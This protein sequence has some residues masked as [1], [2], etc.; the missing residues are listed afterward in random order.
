MSV[1]QTFYEALNGFIKHCRDPHIQASSCVE[2]I[3]NC[4]SYR[5]IVSFEYNAL[6]LIRNVYDKESPD[7]LALSIVKAHGLVAIVKKIVGNDFQ[8]PIEIKGNISEIEAYT[9]R[10]LDENMSNYLGAGKS[11]PEVK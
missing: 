9:K 7:D 2:D 8:I 5:T 11:E 1:E 3:L 10:W 4:D 6:P